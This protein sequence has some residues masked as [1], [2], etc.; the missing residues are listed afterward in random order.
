[1]KLKEETVW[2]TQKQMAGLFGKNV[3]T[4]NEHI[5]NVYKEGELER[6]ATIRKFL[7]VQKEGKRL[8]NRELE[9][10]SLDTICLKED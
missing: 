1:V 6:S 10:Y 9:Y 5:K 4:I 8:V 3:M 7:I 2:M